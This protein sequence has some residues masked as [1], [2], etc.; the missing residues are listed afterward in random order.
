MKYALLL[1]LVMGWKQAIPQEKSM[2]HDE[3]TAIVSA[4]AS[5]G[6]RVCALHPE[7]SVWLT[8]DGKTWDKYQCSGLVEIFKRNH[9]DLV[10]TYV[11]ILKIFREGRP[12]AH[13]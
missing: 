3:I 6:R 2:S 7:E 13:K 11:D 5:V 1:L 10:K 9:A 4:G 12:E 8:Q